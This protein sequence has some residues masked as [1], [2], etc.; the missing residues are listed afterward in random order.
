MIAVPK[1][2]PPTKDELTSVETTIAE[3]LAAA[4]GQPTM[5]EMMVHLSDGAG[6][7]RAPRTTVENLNDTFKRAPPL[8][9]AE[10]ERFAAPRM[11]RVNEIVGRSIATHPV[12]RNRRAQELI[13][14]LV[15][16]ADHVDVVR[17]DALTDAGYLRLFTQAQLVPQM[18]ATKSNAFEPAVNDGLKYLRD[19][20]EAWYKRL[21]TFLVELTCTARQQKMPRCVGSHATLGAWFKAAQELWTTPGDPLAVLDQQLLEIRNAAS[22]EEP[23]IDV[24]AET[25]VSPVDRG[26]VL[27]RDQLATLIAH[28]YIRLF[29]LHLALVAAQHVCPRLRVEP[30]V[31][32]RLSS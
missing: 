32:T 16:N 11:K 29:S 1:V 18:V 26:V 5:E 31:E 27:D 10:F 9:E 22:H 14:F 28:A 7:L 3:V 4:V 15:T 21:V 20:I 24:R 2:K 30:P 13:R 6:L 19:T 17:L 12:L 25:V 8:N 23:D